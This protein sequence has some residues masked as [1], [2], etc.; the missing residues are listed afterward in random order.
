MR[1]HFE[2]TPDAEGRHKIWHA[3]YDADLNKF[4]SYVTVPLSVVVIDEEDNL[5]LCRD[6]DRNVNADYVDVNG[7]N[8]YYIVAGQLSEVTGWQQ[9]VETPEPLMP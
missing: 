6:L 5:D 4:K 2:T 3:I 8:K 9:Y 7:D 1:L